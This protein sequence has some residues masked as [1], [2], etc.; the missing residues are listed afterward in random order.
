MK[1]KRRVKVREIAEVTGMTKSTV[2]EII[3]DLNFFK[4]SACWVLK[5]FTKELK[6]IRIAASFENL[7]HYQDKGELFVESIIIGDEITPKSFSMT[8]KHLHS[9][10][11]KKKM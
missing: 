2:H 6:S 8:W 5:M 11:T 1:E 10:R 7:C 9:F 4:A 3:S